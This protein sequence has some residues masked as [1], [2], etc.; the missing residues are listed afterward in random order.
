MLKESKLKNKEK[1]I[2]RLKPFWKNY[3]D[4]E[5]KFMQKILKLEKEMNKKLTL[6]VEL[7]FFYAEGECVG[8]GASDYSDRKKFPLIQDSEFRDRN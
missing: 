6:G 7:E 1:I 5:K 8:I 4:E 3:W 2:E